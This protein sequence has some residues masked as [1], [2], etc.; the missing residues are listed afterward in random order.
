M[1]Q[2]VYG[3]EVREDSAQV[4]LFKLLV[5]DLSLGRVIRQHREIDYRGRFIKSTTKKRGTSSSYTISA[6]DDEKEYELTQSGVWFVY[7]TMNEMVLKITQQ[8]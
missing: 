5:Y 3:K 4:N 6:F 7:Y 8:K 2:N 1:W